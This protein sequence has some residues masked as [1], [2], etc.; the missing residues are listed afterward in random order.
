MEKTLKSKIV[1]IDGDAQRQYIDAKAVFTALE[2]ARK[3][4]AEVRGGM[5]WRSMGNTDYLVR[6]SA[7]SGQKGLGPRSE[8]TEAIYKNFTERKERARTRVIELRDALI[9]HQRMNKALHVGRAPD[10]LVEL[11]NKLA[12]SGI[13]DYFT[14]IGTHALY[15]YESAAGARFMNPAAMTTRDVD[16]LWDV[17]RRLS[18]VTQMESLGSSFLGLLR[19]VDPSFE[20]RD[21]QHYTAINNDGFEI[22]IIRREKTGDD[23][24]PIRLTDDEDEFLAVEARRAGVLLDGVKFSAMIVSST[25]RMARMNTISPVVFTRFKRW[26]AEQADRDPIKR[27]RDLLQAELVEE[28]TREYLPHI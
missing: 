10:L 13:S 15:A 2:S 25:G 20:I 14:V 9:R 22:D 17:R 6:T 8:Q 11:L 21:D 1:E 5:V 19:K 26:M 23:P 16:L 18:F 4:M 24:H 7:G 27:R 3:S 28:L 12:K